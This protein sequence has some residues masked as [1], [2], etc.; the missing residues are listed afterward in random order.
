MWRHHSRLQP[1]SISQSAPLGLGGKCISFLAVAAVLLLVTPTQAAVAVISNRT[2]A[3]I[4]FTILQSGAQKAADSSAKAVTASQ[5]QFPA[6]KGYSIAAGDLTVV[7]LARGQAARLATDSVNYL[8]E[9]D[10]A[11]YFGK[12]PSGKTDLAR[13][14]VGEVQADNSKTP[15][16]PASRPQAKSAEDA[17]TITVKI[18]ADDSEPAARAVW[19][20]RYRDRIAAISDIVERHC[21]MKLKVIGADT[22]HISSNVADFDAAVD[23]FTRT[24]D[25]GEARLAIGFTGRYQIPSGRM[26]MGGTHGPM[27]HHI[28]VREWAR[29]FSESE[30]LE[31]LLHEVGHFLGAIHSPESDAVMRPLLGDRQSRMVRFQIHFDPLNTL[32]INLVSEEIRNRGVDSFP[33][34]SPPTKAKLRAIY[35]TIGNKMPDDPAAA[36]YLQI[37]EGGAPAFRIMTKEN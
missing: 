25:P 18:F 20:R 3:E 15:E 34:L 17:K 12:L 33:Q 4:R 6:S 32:A 36:Q 31:F 37:L 28:L 35:E 9:P 22:W 27:A 19:E 5:V 1:Q 26:H 23:D 7:P 13:I 10:A 24:V 11:Y 21:G 14:D 2:G 8:I 29:H 30:R 16:T